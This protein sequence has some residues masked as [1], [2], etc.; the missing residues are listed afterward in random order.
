[1][2]SRTLDPGDQPRNV[3]A[4][5][6]P[7]AP[8]LFNWLNDRAAGVLLHPTSLPGPGGIGVFDAAALAFL[9][10]LA[11]AGMRAWQ[12]CPL[13]PTGYG[14]SPYQCFSSF[15]GNP[16]LIDLAPLGPAGLL[17]TAQLDPLRALNP[18]RVDFG[19]LFRLKPP[20]LFA[21]HAAWKR[22]PARELPY[23]DFGAFRARHASWL[24]GFSLFSAIKEHFGGQPWWEW[25]AELRSLAAAKKS[26]LAA[27]LAP[28]AEA[29]EFVQY[30]FFGQWAAIRARAAELGITVI[31]DVPI[32]AALDSAD[33]WSNP[34][35][36]QLDPVT[37]RPTAVAGVPP[38]YF[39]AD[40]QLWGNPLYDWPAHAA[41]GYAWWL[42]R[43]RVNFEHYD[44]IRIDHFRGFD[45]YWSIP[46]GAPTA[47][48]GDWREGPGLAF[49]QALQA[50]MPGARLI[51]EDLGD[52]LPSVIELRDATGLPGMAILQFAFGGGAD[53][54]YLPH[55]HRANSV[56]YPGTHD[57]DTALGWYASLDERTRDHVRRYFRVS[58][59]EIGWDFLRAA[60]AS[61]CNLAI[62]PLQD[63]LS[64]GTDA[65]LNRPG[66]AQGNW[67]WRYRPEQLHALREGA[68]SYLRELAELY[69]R[70]GQ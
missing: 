17:T 28:R 48:T 31:G 8:P 60:Y 61:V 36:F 16:Y 49:F 53:N 38:D 29:Y 9:D 22:R 15:A 12:L 10:F 41:D 6:A 1:M 40:G 52:L 63:L 23:G 4:P 19:A 44:V 56:V 57:N 58:G 24:G 55:N 25:P 62:I 50:A 46:A 13:G 43:L 11:Q 59:R 65:R 45:T 18:D 34:E 42:D 37:L 32:F 66:T 26:A 21:A 39:S 33:V 3:S 35:L 70:D 67:T 51:A 2:S 5:R 27:R 54:L 47:R 20:L 64:L 69:G 68:S 7:A 14:D 30:L